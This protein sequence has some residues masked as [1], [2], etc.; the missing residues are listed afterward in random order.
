MFGCLAQE[1]TESSGDEIEDDDANNLSY[2]GE[3]AYDLLRK[4]HNRHWHACWNVTSGRVVD[5]HPTPLPGPGQR[6]DDLPEPH[7][8]PFCSRMC[9]I[10]SRTQHWCDICSLSPPNGLFMDKFKQALAD[11]AVNAQSK[12]EDDP[13]IVRM[14]FG[15]IIGQPV[16]CDAVMRQL[17][18]DL[19]EDANVNLWVGAWRTGVSWNH[20]KIIAA[21]GRY[22]HTGGHNLWYRH[23]NKLD[24][25]HDLSFELEG[26]VAHDGH[27][28]AN[29]QWKFIEDQQNGFIGKVV[30]HLPDG[31]PTPLQTRVTVSQW[32]EDIDEFAPE[33]AKDCVPHV[34][35]VDRHVPIITMGRF[36]AMLRKDR[37]SDDAFVAMFDSAQKIIHMALQDLGPITL[38]E[39]PGPITVP[40]CVW[41]K[42]YLEAFGRAIW[43]REV[44]IEIVLSNPRSIPDNLSPTEANYGNGWTCADVASEIIK[45]IKDQFG[46]VDDEDLREKVSENLRV[47]YIKQNQ[48]TTWPTGKTLG[49]H[50][51]HFIIDDMAY[52]IGSQNLYIADL[53][54]WGVLVDSKE[55]TQRAMEIYWYPIWKDSF[56]GTDCDVEDVMDGLD[57]DR[58]GGSTM[59]MDDETKQLV[60]QAQ[61]AASNVPDDDADMYE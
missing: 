48:C 26:R 30:S 15:N 2:V 59:F 18:A 27:L 22:L 24:P 42:A 57:I 51:K 35:I 47:C 54:E 58:S 25:I 56:T 14:M 29:K 36:G 41:P 10:M 52:Y 45:T 5:L 4:E 21:D 50:A 33:Y 7:D 3:A 28:F 43:V 39:I 53:A 44:D 16:N 17:T 11:I 46:D 49:Y 31:V 32:P 38:P 60:K 55:E 20:A 37:P 61:K 12:D 8:Q 40:G 13:I 9:E 1:E 34:G 23:Y 6:I 19:D